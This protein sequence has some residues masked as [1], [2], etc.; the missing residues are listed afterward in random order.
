MKF[1]K[2]QN[3]L[4]KNKNKKPK[5]N[6]LFVISPFCTPYSIVLTFAFDRAVLYGNVAFSILVPSTKKMK[7]QF[8]KKGFGLSESFFR[9]YSFSEN[10]Q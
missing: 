3:S 8:F 2:K 4:K 1:S 7:L 6:T 10:L 9:K 5:K